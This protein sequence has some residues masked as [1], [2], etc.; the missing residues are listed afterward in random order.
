MSVER[1]CDRYRYEVQFMR[2]NNL[3]QNFEA[4]SNLATAYA[5]LKKV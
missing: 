3:F 5:R 1:F 4:W 2:N